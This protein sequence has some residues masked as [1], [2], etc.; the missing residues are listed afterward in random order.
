M[1]DWTAATLAVGFVGLALRLT[2]AWMRGF[3]GFLEWCGQNTVTRRERRPQDPEYDPGAGVEVVVRLPSGNVL[4]RQAGWE[5]GKWGSVSTRTWPNGN[6]SPARWRWWAWPWLKKEW[7]DYE[8]EGIVVGDAVVV[9]SLRYG[10]V[11]LSTFGRLAE[12]FSGSAYGLVV[13]YGLIRVWSGQPL[14][15]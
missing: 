10:P 9:V 15:P 5:T 12:L 14:L 8:E 7:H 11:H 4:V 1:D 6:M 13:I 2:A 3:A